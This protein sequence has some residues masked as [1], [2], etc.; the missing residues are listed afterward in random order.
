MARQKEYWNLYADHCIRHP[1]D[2]V[3]YITFRQRV[4]KRGPKLAIR[5]GKRQSAPEMAKIHE[6]RRNGFL[7][8]KRAEKAKQTANMAI[9]ILL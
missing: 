2:A 1:K 9:R 4:L 7:R 6:E 8:Q 3:S 5:L